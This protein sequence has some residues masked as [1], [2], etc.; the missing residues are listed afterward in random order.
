MFTYRQNSRVLWEILVGEHDGDVRFFT[1]S[2]NMAVPRMRNE[3]N[4]QLVFTC[5]RIAYELGYGGDTVFH[6]TYFLL[7]F[8]Y[9]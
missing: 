9:C 1:E 6:R 3:K 7:F 4:M 8:Y 5:G 2:R